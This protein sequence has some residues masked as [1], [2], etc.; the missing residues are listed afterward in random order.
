[1]SIQPKLAVVCL[2]MALL[3]VSPGLSSAEEDTLPEPVK[4]RFLDTICS[5]VTKQA[6]C[7]SSGKLVLGLSVGWISFEACSVAGEVDMMAQ[8]FDRAYLLAADLTGLP[9]Y[10][11]AYKGC[12]Q[13]SGGDYNIN[14]AI[15]RCYREGFKY[16]RFSRKR[17]H[18][19]GAD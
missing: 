6:R 19:R 3:W 17:F 1:M 8:C 2:A 9:V 14:D 10:A 15:V 5:D 12:H 13:I 16:S 18:S 11:E 4:Q 7:F